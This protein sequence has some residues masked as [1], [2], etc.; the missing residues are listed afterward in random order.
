MNQEQ[1]Q[2]DDTQAAPTPAAPKPKK[3][4]AKAKPMKKIAPK[5]KAK[6]KKAKGTAKGMGVLRE[7]A[8]DYEHPKGKDGKPLKTVNGNPVVDSG[9]EIAR[10]MRGKDL[11]QVYDAVSKRIGQSVQALKLKYGKLN[12]GQQRMNLGNRLRG[13]MNAKAKPAKKAAK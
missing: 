10:A 13:F 8:P 6:V 3:V 5:V 4:K 7:Y 2:V 12:P 9:D 1:T 11:G